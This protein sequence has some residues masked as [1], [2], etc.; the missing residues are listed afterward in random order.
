MAP[1]PVKDRHGRHRGRRANGI[2]PMWQDPFVV[3]LAEGRIPPRALRREAIL[4][5][6][7]SGESSPRVR[8]VAG[9]SPHDRVT[10]P[11]MPS[12]GDQMPRYRQPVHTVHLTTAWYRSAVC[13]P[14]SHRLP[15]VASRPDSMALPTATDHDAGNWR[16][17]GSPWRSLDAFASGRGWTKDGGVALTLDRGNVPGVTGYG[18]GDRASEWRDAEPGRLLAPSPTSDALCLPGIYD[19]I[20]EAGGRREPGPNG[21]AR[22][23]HCYRL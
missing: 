13:G 10:L 6:S 5:G 2:P 12:R 22:Q 7:L 9:C 20:S 18:P 4:A 16:E 3:E 15:N 11:L 14:P 17:P 23:H 8:D 21:I 19:G 1:S